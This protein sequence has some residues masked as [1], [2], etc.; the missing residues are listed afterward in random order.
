MKTLYLLR[1]AETDWNEAGKLQ[2]RHN[3]HL[4]LKGQNQAKEAKERYKDLQY[5]VI[6]CSPLARAR[7]T[8][9]IIKGDKNIPLIINDGLIERDY[10]NYEGYVIGKLDN[11]KALN[12]DENF[13]GELTDDAAKRMKE[14]LLDIC[15]KCD[16]EKIMISTHGGLI[17]YFLELAYKE[18]NNGLTFD[19]HHLENCSINV[20]EYD[21]EKE[22]FIPTGEYWG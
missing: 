7:E 8:I 17:G 15:K 14:T 16:K 18:L 3:T 6:Y 12:D 13:T 21:E 4:S 22:I 11:L 2:G 10:G 5:D 19:Y 1:H 20:V 9:E